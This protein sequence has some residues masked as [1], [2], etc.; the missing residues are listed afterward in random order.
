MCRVIPGRVWSWLFDVTMRRVERNGLA[1]LRSGLVSKAHGGTLEI[2]AGTGAN[3]RFYPSAASP[4][5]LTEPDLHK[6]RRLRH[7]TSRTRPDAQTIVARAYPLPFPDASFDTV[8]VTLVLCSVPDQVQALAEVRRV[9]RPGGRLLYI[10][11]VRAEDPHLA[12]RQDRWRPVWR[13]VAGGCEPNRD[14]TAAI[15]AAGF[16]LT[17]LHHGRMPAA[18]AI[19]R[20]L[21]Y[22]TATRPT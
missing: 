3:V 13:A 5:V 11:H 22:G 9:L 18:P 7:R 12:R 17:D 16:E 1:A 2:G 8:L 10:E 19:V 15:R 20:P 14:T 6:L 4:L 21:A